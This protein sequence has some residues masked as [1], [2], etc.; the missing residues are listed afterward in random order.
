MLPCETTVKT[1][2]PGIKSNIAKTLKANGKKQNEIA[3]VLGVTEAAVSMYINGQRGAVKTK[4]LDAVR[5]K[6]HKEICDVCTTMQ[7]FCKGIK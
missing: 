4:K 6:Q 5:L 2:V 7:T 1:I 3:K